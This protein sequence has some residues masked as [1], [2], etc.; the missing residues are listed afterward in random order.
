MA[1]A[2]ALELINDKDFFLELSK[3]DSAESAQKL[4]ASRGANISIDELLAFR[5]GLRQEAGAELSD[6]ELSLIAGGV[7]PDF[8]TTTVVMGRLGKGW[9]DIGKSLDKFFTEDVVDFFKED[10]GGFF[11][12]YFPGW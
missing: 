5:A 2:K 8:S 3:T 10:V 4:F 12:K 6:E 1:D 11:N 7:Y 9:G